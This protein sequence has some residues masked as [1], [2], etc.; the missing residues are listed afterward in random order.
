MSYFLTVRRGDS[1]EDSYPILATADPDLI[2]LVAKGLARKLSAKPD[3]PVRLS[4]HAKPH[5][6]SKDKPRT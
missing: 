5:D 3:P 1:P 2:E 4:S 6:D